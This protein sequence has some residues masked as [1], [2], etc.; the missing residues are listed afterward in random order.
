MNRQQFFITLQ[1][2]LHPLPAGERE[3]VIFYYREIIDDSMEEGLTEEEAVARLGN[4]DDLVREIFISI[5]E[6]RKASIPAGR[7]VRISILL[8]LGFPLWGSVLLVVLSLVLVAFILALLPVILLGSFTLTFFVGGIWAIVG[9]P[10]VILGI[11]VS[12]GIAQLGIGIAALGLSV[13]SA[14]ALGFTLKGVKTACR[15]LWRF[16]KK[17]L[18]WRMIIA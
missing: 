15:A 6:R 8:A 10:F 3:K 2:E 7:K 1:Q 14:V 5:D 11:T 4:M 12:S 9:S 13:L 17:I 18:G 16:V